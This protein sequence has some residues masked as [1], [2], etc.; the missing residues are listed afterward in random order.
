M[1]QIDIILNENGHIQTS[2]AG[3]VIGD[4]NAAAMT[5]TLAGTWENIDYFRLLFAGKQECKITEKLYAQNG[6]L[7]YLLPREVTLLGRTVLCQIC[8]Y[9]GEEEEVSILFKSDSFPLV[10]GSSLPDT[11]DLAGSPLVDSLNQMLSQVEAIAQNF[12]LRIGKVESLN[13]GEN[14]T[15][16]VTPEADGSFTLNLG[17]P[18]GEKGEGNFTPGEHIF[19]QN[20]VISADSCPT[21]YVA[22]E[23]PYEYIGIRETKTV[24][25]LAGRIFWVNP[26]YENNNSQVYFYTSGEEVYRRLY[27]MDGKHLNNTLPVGCVVPGRVMAIYVNEEGVPVY[28]NPF[29]YSENPL[30]HYTVTPDNSGTLPYLSINVSDFNQFVNGKTIVATAMKDI[31][32]NGNTWYGP[33]YSSVTFYNGTDW[34]GCNSLSGKTI[35]AGQPLLFYLEYDNKNYSFKTVRLLNPP[36]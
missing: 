34:V 13:Y 36:T 2:S 28:L 35:K 22:L 18:R 32:F 15:A 12:D 10:F 11:T 27:R 30:P 29:E 9:A 20:G 4:H 26:R 25:Q 3:G 24:E 6:M 16:S 33:M 19:I 31:A 8:G 5:V 14:A 17:L 7:R 1:K 23:S 21:V